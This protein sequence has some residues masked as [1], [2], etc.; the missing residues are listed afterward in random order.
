VI[1]NGAI[2]NASG[3]ASM[4]TIAKAISQLKEKPKRS[5]LFA[6]VAA[7]E[8]GLLGSKYLAERPPVP[9]GKIAAVV[10]MDGVNF[11]GRS[12][13]VN[14]VGDGKS[15]LDALVKQVAKWQKRIVT[16]DNFP[17]KGYY[18]RSD[19]FSLAKIGVPG[20]YLHAGINIIGKP[21]GWGKLQ[22]E[23]WT[24]KHYHQPSDEYRE[25]W[26]LSGA[27][28]D[29]QLLYA[30]GALIANQPEMPKWNA[31][32]EF[33]AARKKAIQDAAKD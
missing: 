8:S 17:E 12:K 5:I 19:Q 32:D 3:V 20:V 11:L 31:G 28:E 26:D 22:N 7:E 33:E 9:A 10:N 2:D 14:V 24:E 16:P 21:D 29:V 25:D 4:L 1:Y 27:M 6:S 23:E 30:V 13:D 15:D 18:Y